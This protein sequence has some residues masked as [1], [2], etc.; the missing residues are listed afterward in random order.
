[1]LFK[2]KSQ[3]I[4]LADG[5]TIKLETGK[6]AGLAHG[7]ALVTQ[8]K[9]ML[10]AT[11]V[12][13]KQTQNKSF[14]P[15]SVDYQEKYAAAGKIPG[16]FLKREG[17]LSDHEVLVCRLVDRAIR[18]CFPKNYFDNIQVRIMLLSADKDV[19]P[20]PL[21][22]LAASTALMLSPVPFYDPISEVR[23]ARIDG[24]FVI[25]P[26]P[27]ALETADIDIIVA[28]AHDR[29]LMIEGEMKEVQEEDLLEA[30]K[31]GHEEVKKQC[32]AQKKLAES[33]G[34]I[35]EEMPEEEVS[36]NEETY[37]E[38][39]YQPIYQ[40]A[41]QAFPSKEE[42]KK[43]F[44]QIREDYI[45][46]LEE[47]LTEEEE[48]EL[49]EHF[50]DI[51]SQAIRDLIMKENKRIDGRTPSDIRE[52]AV[53]V[54]TLPSVHGSS[55]FTRGE[56]QGLV[57]LTLGG[58]QDEQLI[59]GVTKSGYKKIMLHY[60]FPSF[61]TG[62]VRPSRGPSRREIGHG[63]LALRALNPILPSEEDNP[64]TM[65]L[66]SI[67]LASNG[68][69]SMATVCGSSLALMDAGIKMP[70]TVAGIAMG[71]ISDTDSGKNIVLSD[72]LGE[73]DKVGDMD[74]KVTGTKD[75]MTACQMD[76][77]VAGI[78]YDLLKKALQQAK[79]GRLHIIEIMEKVI[80]KPRTS[81]KAHVPRIETFKIPRDTIGAI[82]GPGG[83]IIQEMQRTTG[84]TINVSE[85]GDQGIVYVLAPDKES[86]DHATSIIQGIVQGPEIGQVYTGKVRS[87]QKYGAFVEFMP[88]TDG[89]LHISQV[90][91]E[92][93]TEDQLR[94]MLPIGKEIRVKLTEI[95]GGKYSL[96]AKID[97]DNVN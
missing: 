8:G 90:S 81:F 36:P 70:K 1:M 80:D 29:V 6:L 9:A 25:N 69:S 48:Q 84:A 18:P 15:L 42:R 64:Y 68:S 34:I 62:E 26:S 67:V 2:P 82:I 5:T 77:K 4:T 43:A 21:A 95:K 31:F 30:I 57:S 63:N 74:F 20:D 39:F 87:V 72:I 7:S 14:L 55:L 44:K 50:S 92:R 66:H 75:G 24:E 49:K 17:K 93:I 65:R 71:L 85:E 83:K 89:L 78:S 35:K 97:D 76:I 79:Q 73:E 3:T 37:K 59:D 96:S 54:D 40:V 38:A 10:L 22:A 11:V 53:E 23:V 33:V 45:A 56:T 91:K 86:L 52:I 19:S 28:A 47:P 60:D 61:S 51:Q 27:V 41:S 58:K 12:A 16:G 88:S 32:E 46:N 13:E 94:E